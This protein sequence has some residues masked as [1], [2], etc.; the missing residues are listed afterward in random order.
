M[1]PAFIADIENRKRRNHG[2]ELHASVDV[3]GTTDK[4]KAKKEKVIK[5][6]GGGQM[7]SMPSPPSAMEEAKAREWE[8]E[9]KFAREQTRTKAE[10]EEKAIAD[11]NKLQ[12][13]NSGRN[14]ALENAR[15]FGRQQL[16]SRGM[17]DDPYGIM[18]AYNQRLDTA[19]SGLQ[20]NDAYASAFSPTVFDQTYND[21]RG[22]LRSTKRRELSNLVPDDYS[23]QQFGRT[24]DDGILDAILGTQYESAKNDLLNARN[25]GGLNDSTYTRA[26][27][28]LGSRKLA[29][30]SELDDIGAGVLSGYRTEL[31]T[32]RRNTLDKANNWEFG[33]TF[34]RDREVGRITGFANERKGRL[35]G[36]INRAVGERSFF[37]TNNIIGKAASSI[38]ATNPGVTGG[39]G[40]TST[41]P[42]YA[43]FTDQQRNLGNQGA[44]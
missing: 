30:R 18:T 13:W 35:E 42:L 39:T 28:N 9:Q 41:N 23:E 8:N 7:P 11:A 38:G 27:S 20:D 4:K 14:T 31:D 19:N 33:D 21:R 25:R 10:K 26:L 16:T 43:A 44:F 29:A 34:D 24:A 3:A 6:K 40:G 1:I 12:K 32:Q 22:E 5:A 2:T 37:D 36:D 15:S 17:T